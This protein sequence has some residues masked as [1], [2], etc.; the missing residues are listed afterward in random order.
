MGV[1]AYTA[2]M[3][4]N[5]QPDDNTPADRNDNVIPLPSR[6]EREA[7][8]ERDRRVRMRVQLGKTVTNPMHGTAA[9]N[10]PMINL[11]PF[12]KIMVLVLVVIHAALSVQN[13]EMRYWIIEHFGFTPAYYTGDLAFGWPALAGP[14]TFTLLHGGWVHLLMN[15]VML[16]AFGTGLERWMGW[17]KLL[18]LILGCNLAAVLVHTGLNIGS[19]DPVIGASGALS[20]M[21]AAAIIMM[22]QQSGFLGNGK[23]RY[24][25]LIAVWI[26]IA[27]L[28]GMMGGP[29]GESIAWAAHIGGFLAGFVLLNPILKLKI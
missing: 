2:P 5:D 24:A 9:Q 4:D 23:Y 3:H 19:T 11:P 14:L 13:P 22:Q 1:P 12:T 15:A 26:G 6:A 29:G 28:F 7:Q 8:Q 27:V 25:P 21:F 20:G 18:L 16:M 10:P 17:E